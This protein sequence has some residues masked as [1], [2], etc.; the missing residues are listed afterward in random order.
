MSKEE[1]HEKEDVN[2]ILNHSN[3]ASMY[4]KNYNIEILRKEEPMDN[5][6]CVVE[7]IT[8][9]NNEN[10]YTVLKCASKSQHDLITV[11]GIMPDTHVGSVLA[12]QGFWKVDAKYG[13][14]F[15]VEK[16]EE[17]LPATE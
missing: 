7:R 9:Q 1:C 10:G 14:Q 17:T 15:C 13:R 12:L 5:L 6:N 16:F 4:I 11:V 2:M 8:Y 3:I